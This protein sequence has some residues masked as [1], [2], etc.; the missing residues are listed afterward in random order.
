VTNSS[1]V[2]ELRFWWREYT[3]A[4]DG[5]CMGSAVNGFIGAFDREF[6]ATSDS[7]KGYVGAAGQ[8][9]GW[10]EQ[11]ID[12]S[13]AGVEEILLMFVASSAS[14]GVCVIAVDNVTLIGL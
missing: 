10:R 1:A 3:G 11:V 9:S 7:G 2:Y 6:G 8:D 12:F 13:V 4:G 14:S 5:G